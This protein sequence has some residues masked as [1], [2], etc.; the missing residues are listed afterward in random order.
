MLTKL[1]D[2]FFDWIRDVARP[3]LGLEPISPLS[4]DE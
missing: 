4:K 3:A 2:M 1:V